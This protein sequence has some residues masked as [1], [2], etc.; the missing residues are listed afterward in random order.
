MLWK[1]VDYRFLG[2]YYPNVRKLAAKAVLKIFSNNNLQYEE[3][4]MSKLR[5]ISQTGYS[6]ADSRSY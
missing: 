5:E 2:E 6:Q 3:D 4:V 1:N